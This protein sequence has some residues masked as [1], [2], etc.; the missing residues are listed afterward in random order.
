MPIYH[1]V[2]P[3]TWEVFHGTLYEAD[4]LASE[5]FIHCSFGEQLDAVLKRYYSAAERVKV[6]EIDPSKLTSKLVVEPSTNGE[7]YPHV[8][9]PIDRDAIVRVEERKIVAVVTTH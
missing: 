2:L 8:Y 1:I 3:E 4:S 7:S 5:G 6:L 9:G